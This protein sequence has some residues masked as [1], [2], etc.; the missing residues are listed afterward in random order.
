MK[1]LK[2]S[3]IAELKY[4]TTAEG[5]RMT[6]AVSGYRPAI[7]FP[8]DKILTSGKQVFLDKKNVDPRD[9]V[10]A[11][12][13]ILATSYFKNRLYE[14]LDFVFTEGE[15]IIGTVVIK[16]IINKDLKKMYE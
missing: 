11:E 13:T 6:A 5:G 12:I 3:F 9:T 2:P 8:F 1:Y 4:K 16:E 10:R 7:K 14:G 15:R